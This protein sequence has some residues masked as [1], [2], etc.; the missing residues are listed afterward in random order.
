MPEYPGGLL[1][2]PVAGALDAIGGALLDGAGEAHGRLADPEDQEALHDFRVAL[3]RLRT[4]S[5][6]APPLSGLEPSSRAKG[7]AR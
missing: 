5:R 6:K 7:V 1:G 4:G 2:R 3:R